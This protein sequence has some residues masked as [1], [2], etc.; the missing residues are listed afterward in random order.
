MQSSAKP[1][2]TWLV[3]VPPHHDTFPGFYL[4]WLAFAIYMTL[5]V[6]TA[7][8]WIIAAVQPASMQWR[9][10]AIAVTLFTVV[11]LAIVFLHESAHIYVARRYGLKS[12]PENISTRFASVPIALEGSGAEGIRAVLAGPIAGMLLVVVVLP[13]VL[14][15]NGPIDWAILGL[16]VMGL[17]QFIPLRPYDGYYVLRD[18]EC[19][20]SAAD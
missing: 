10:I 11:K 3:R 9:M 5:V 12:S 20:Y 16:A 1:H 17:E 13:L 19:F 18:R 14:L 2:R 15:G 8:S 6:L 4:T 7:A